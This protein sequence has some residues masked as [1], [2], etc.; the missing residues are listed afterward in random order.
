MN[1]PKSLLGNTDTWFLN[2]DVSNWAA[3]GATT[4]TGSAGSAPTQ[5][6]YLT[7]FGDSSPISLNDIH[8]GQ[9][10]D[11]FLL[12]PIGELA[13]KDPS[14]IQSMIHVNANGTETVTLYVD[15]FG[16]VPYP[17]ETGLRAVSVTVNNVFPS[18]SVNNGSTQDVVGNQKEIWPQVLEKA[19]A[20]L[21][22]GYGAIANGGNPAEAMEE[23]TGKLAAA[24][25]PASISA[26]QLSSFAAAGDMITFDTASKS[27]L[28]DNLVGN[29]AYMFEKVVGS[30]SAASVQLAN[31]WGTDQPSLIPVSQFAKA[32]VEIDVGR[33]A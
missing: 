11:C 13:L 22:G 15:R 28:P 3:A 5:T 24:Y 27:S 4:Q 12:S 2:D 31:P 17:G 30:G 9:I 10:G 16:H 8:Q 33:T 1:V 21:E 19:V 18:Y 29:H 14:A 32:F 20:T 6:L 23:L 7:E 26:A 25:N